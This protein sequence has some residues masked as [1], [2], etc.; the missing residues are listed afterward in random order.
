LHA[1]ITQVKDEY[2]L[3]TKL[4]DYLSTR[5]QRPQSSIMIAISHS[6]CLLYGGTF[7]P[8]YILTLTAVETYMQSAT[9][10]RNTAM[11]QS[12]LSQTLNVPPERGV[13]R[14]QPIK[15]DCLGTCGKTVAG[16]IERVEVV[17]PVVKRNVTTSVRKTVANALKRR[18]TNLSIRSNNSPTGSGPKSPYLAEKRRSILSMARSSKEEDRLQ[19]KDSKAKAK[20][21]S[22]HPPDLSDMMNSPFSSRS[23]LSVPSPVYIDRADVQPEQQP[24]TN[25]TATENL[26]DEAARLLSMHAS[27]NPEGEKSN[28]EPPRGRTETSSNHPPPATTEAPTEQPRPTAD[29]PARDVP[30][31]SAQDAQPAAAT[32]EPLQTVAHGAAGQP[33]HAA[34]SHRAN[35]AAGAAT[36]AAKT[37]PHPHAE[38]L[39]P[40]PAPQPR[41]PKVSRRKSLLAIF[42]R[43][44]APKTVST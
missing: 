38:P 13:V 37:Q 11:L 10:K 1:D 23:S 26:L 4:S 18:P 3:V 20:R 39:A 12:F 36:Q 14:F 31:T 32:A 15:E 41:T 5:Y 21:V 19:R 9:N 42:K 35:A 27:Q 16:E 34:P 30:A 8:G 28:P 44:S 6:S 22:L 25:E 7:D 17:E 24:S 2:S 29:E 40:L 43:D 33:G